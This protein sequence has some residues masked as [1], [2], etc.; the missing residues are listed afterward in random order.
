MKF[1]LSAILPI[2]T[3]RE[4][5]YDLTKDNRKRIP[6]STFGYAVGGHLNANITIKAHENLWAP[7]N[8][9]GF[10]FDKAENEGDVK[11]HEAEEDFMDTL[12]TCVLTKPFETEAS[13]RAKVDEYKNSN[14]GAQLDFGDS[15]VQAILNEQRMQNNNNENRVFLY[16]LNI[17]FLNYFYRFLRRGSIRFRKATQS[18]H[19]QNFPFSQWHRGEKYAQ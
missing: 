17:I 19:P 6:L 18:Y 13:L 1:F 7:G 14:K 15:A 2:L 16:F 10:T 5:H 11:R 8:K 4:H 9:F 12:N 3:A